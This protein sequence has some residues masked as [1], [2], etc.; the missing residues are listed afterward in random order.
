MGFGYRSRDYSRWGR[1]WL[2]GRL[3]GIESFKNGD[4]SDQQNTTSIFANNS[5]YT[6]YSIEAA[7]YLTK[8]LGISVNFTSAF[9]GEIIFASPSYSVG[10]FLDL[11]R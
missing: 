7:A 10:V 3:F 2:I 1:L 6:S 8:T 9:R 4:T 5:E 11:S